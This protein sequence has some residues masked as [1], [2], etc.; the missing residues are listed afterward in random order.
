MESSPF[1]V[2]QDGAMVACGDGPEVLVYLTSSGA[3]VWK[4]FADGIL[5]G[6]AFDASR[7]LG[8]DANGRLYLWEFGSGQLEQQHDLALEARCMALAADGAVLIGGISGVHLMLPGGML[9]HWPLSCPTG[10][11]WMGTVGAVGTADGVFSLVD[12]TAGLRPVC[13]LDGGIVDVCASPLGHWVVATTDRV[14][15]LERDGTRVKQVIDLP[16]KQVQHAA[17]SKDGIVVAAA[18]GDGS[19]WLGDSVSVHK[20][21]EV[22]SRRSWEGLAFGQGL[23]LAVGHEDGDA[24]FVDLSS[25]KIV[26]SDAHVGRARRAWHMEVHVN[27]A[28]VRGARVNVA[29]GGQTVASYTG[30][31]PED[32]RPSWGKWLLGLA[33]GCLVLVLGT[34]AL[35]VISALVLRSRGL[36]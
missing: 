10:A 36:G 13:T 26:Q 22:L 32:D 25:S 12:R 30:P 31:R 8:M 1:A 4:A 5:V 24:S 11:D 6:L 28:S 34:G 7:L 23:L 35:V 17:V 27:L 16:G 18:C 21:G 3:P 14:T 29:S 15:F 9:Q 19:V 33:G 2:S 20:A